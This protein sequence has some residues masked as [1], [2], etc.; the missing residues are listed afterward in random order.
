VAAAAELL[1]GLV[2]AR[3]IVTAKGLALMA[4][5]HANGD[6]GRCP[7]V[8]CERQLCVPAGMADAPRLHTVKLYCPR[9]RDL[10]A[11]PAVRH[12]SLDGAFF[13]TTFPHLL[14]QTFPELLPTPPVRNYT[15]RLFG[16]RLHRPP[17]QPRPVHEQILVVE[18]SKK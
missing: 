13:G 6:F 18:T 11:P 9:C 16:F 7:R 5:K 3:F 15:P 10:Y 4:Q 2:H 12:T 1:Y 17:T 14:F 8:N